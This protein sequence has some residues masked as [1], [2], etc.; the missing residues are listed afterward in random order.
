LTS[1]RNWVYFIVPQIAEFDLAFG[2]LLRDGEKFYSS[3][4]AGKAQ[5]EKIFDDRICRDYVD[6][7]DVDRAGSGFVNRDRKQSE[8]RDL[9]NSGFSESPPP[10][11]SP[12]ASSLASSPSP[13]DVA[14]SNG[15]KRNTP[16]EFSES[17]GVFSLQQK[18]FT[19]LI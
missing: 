11:L 10:S 18:H 4:H 16:R 3:I 15:E 5:H 6:D 13:P 9:Y 12:L 19:R 7:F 17:R 2:E 14:I 1:R 8:R